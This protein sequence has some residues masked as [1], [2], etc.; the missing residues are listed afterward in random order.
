MMAVDDRLVGRVGGA[1]WSVDEP[2]ARSEWVV[3]L[4]HVNKNII[5]SFIRE[6]LMCAQHNEKY[7]NVT[8]SYS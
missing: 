7:A 1:L 5:H 4:S 2:I 3:F 8:Y 6:F